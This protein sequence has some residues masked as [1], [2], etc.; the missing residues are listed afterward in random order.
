MLI[1][2]LCLTFTLNFFLYFAHADE[3]KRANLRGYKRIIKWTK[4][5]GHLVILETLEN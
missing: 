5:Y 1:S 2:P 4:A 3:A